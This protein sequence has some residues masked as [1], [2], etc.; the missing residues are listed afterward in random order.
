ML[1]SVLGTSKVLKQGYSRISQ[2]CEMEVPSLCRSNRSPKVTS[3]TVSVECRGISSSYKAVY[4]TEI[5]MGE[6]IRNLCVNL[7]I[8]P[9]TRNGVTKNVHVFRMSQ[10][11]EFVR[12]D[13]S[14]EEANHSIS[15][16][17]TSAEIEKGEFVLFIKYDE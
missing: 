9:D 10:Y 4:D 16:L 6:L 7:N 14:I 2:N 13:Q 1:L 15:K 11:G 5:C 17:F 8:D 3:M 12:Y